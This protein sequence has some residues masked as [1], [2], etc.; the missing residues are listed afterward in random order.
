MVKS[1]TLKNFVCG[2]IAVRYFGKGGTFDWYYGDLEYIFSQSCYK[3]D[4]YRDR[5]TIVT[6][7]NFEKWSMELELLW[8]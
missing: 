3:L 6:V 5:N 7:E 8:M 1:T 4:N 2:L